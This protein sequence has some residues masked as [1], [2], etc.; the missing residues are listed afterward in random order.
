MNKILLP[1]IAVIII[2]GI[3]F[4]INSSNNSAKAPA[5]SETKKENVVIKVD[6]SSTVYPITE[7]VAEE[8]QKENSDV[9]VT[10][11]IAGTGG[12]FKKFCNKETDISD[13]SRP[14]KSTEAEAC[15][16]KDIEYIEL[17]IAFDGLS[18]MVN[19]ENDWV[20]DMTV[21]ELKMLWEPEAQEKIT[22][23]NQIRSTFPNEE[24]HLFG[25][26]VDSGTFDYFTGAI[27]GE[28]GK[29]RGDYTAS[30]DDNVLVQGI[31]TDKY[32]LGYF[33]VAYY[34]Q[35]KDKLK[36][37]AIDDEDDTNG[38]GAILPEYNN[39][40]DGT[41]QPLA[42]PIFIYV[43][44]QALEKAEVKN[45][46]DYYLTN[47]GTLS[48][49]VGYIALPDEVSNLVKNKFADKKTGSV[50]ADGAKGTIK[51]LLEKN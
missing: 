22:K 49:E 31:S 26:G 42:R 10:V 16:A 27:V 37:I 15:A 1:V 43:S 44:T 14:I 8:Y 4:Y 33:G 20:K 40:A 21:T 19:P 29:S 11:G 5:Q 32:A 51:E 24:I 12:G 48:K 47:G 13:A 36:L 41:Y 9:K 35:N 17:P 28:E 50:Y 38:E 6:G 23:W 45:F 34:E 39:V 18:V 30:E 25:P 7:A 2:A 3:V 46:V